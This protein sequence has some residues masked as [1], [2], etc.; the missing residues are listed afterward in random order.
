MFVMLLAPLQQ[1]SGD[2]NCDVVVNVD[3]LLDVISDWGPCTNCNSDFDGNDLVDVQ[4]LL[5]V[6]QNWTP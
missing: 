2:S 3:D 4:D 1:L 6:L 5:A